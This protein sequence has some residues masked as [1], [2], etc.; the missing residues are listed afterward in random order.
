MILEFFIALSS[1]LVGLLAG[2]G[3]VILLFKELLKVVVKQNADP[4][5]SGKT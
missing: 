3:I 2:M 5:K 1:F 4:K